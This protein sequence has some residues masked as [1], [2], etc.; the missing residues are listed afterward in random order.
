MQ[1]E[2]A[3][4]SANELRI[5]E[6]V[7]VDVTRI[8]IK[9]GGVKSSQ[10]RRQGRS[11]VVGAAVAVEV[12]IFNCRRRRSAVDPTARA[13]SARYCIV[14][15]NA[16]VDYRRCVRQGNRAAMGRGISV[17]GT[18]LNH[19]TATGNTHAAAVASGGITPSVS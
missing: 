15:Y 9:I 4:G 8:A 13:A 5:Q 16:T 14:T 17:E 1:I 6:N 12:T 2:I 3:N 7:G 18:V 11:G 10:S 19:R